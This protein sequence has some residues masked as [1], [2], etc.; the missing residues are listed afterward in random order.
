MAIDN[1][2]CTWKKTTTNIVI[3][4]NIFNLIIQKKQKHQDIGYKAIKSRQFIVY[5]KKVH[6]L[7]SFMWTLISKYIQ[8]KTK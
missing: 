6:N 2:M 8:N 3:Y 5:L 1:T 4:T 7:D